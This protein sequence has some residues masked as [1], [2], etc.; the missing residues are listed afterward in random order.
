MS[1]DYVNFS[2]CMHMD[3]VDPS[4]GLYQIFKSIVKDREALEI[5]SAK[6]DP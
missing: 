5:Q 1:T 2:Q 4:N 6:N 3:H